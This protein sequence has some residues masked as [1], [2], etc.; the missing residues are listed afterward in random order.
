MKSLKNILISGMKMNI[1]TI[2]FREEPANS[3]PHCESTSDIYVV[4]AMGMSF[5]Y[6]E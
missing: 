4:K 2:T 1:M 3:S 5:S 6:H